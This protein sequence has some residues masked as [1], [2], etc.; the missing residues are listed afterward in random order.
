MTITRTCISWV[1]A[2]DIIR[3]LKAQRI[4]SPCFIPQKSLIPPHSSLT[5]M[6][7]SN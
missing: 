7:P 4:L 6:S 1:L 5:F 2:M 3:A